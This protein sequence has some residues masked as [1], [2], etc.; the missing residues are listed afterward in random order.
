MG[1][2]G[3]PSFWLHVFYKRHFDLT[4]KFFNTLK[5]KVQKFPN[6][7][8]LIIL[9][10]FNIDILDDIN[11]KNNKKQL[12]EFMNCKSKYQFKNKT[13]FCPLSYNKFGKQIGNFCFKC[14]SP[15]PPPF[16][17]KFWNFLYQIFVSQILEGGGGGEGCVQNH[18][19]NPCSSYG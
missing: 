6:D 18:G 19:S 14:R 9:G 15:P 13:K 10:N 2:L 17:P 8:R 11:H 7:C 3:V 12:M 16:P 4:S 5:T 1:V